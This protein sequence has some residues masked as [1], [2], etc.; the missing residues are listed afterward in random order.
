MQFVDGVVDTVDGK[1]DFDSA[2]D[3]EEY[4]FTS[5]VVRAV[6]AKFSR[7]RVLGRR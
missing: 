4:A 7:S 3:G 6:E 1:N 5:W 2:R